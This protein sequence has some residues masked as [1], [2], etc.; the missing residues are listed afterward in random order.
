MASRQE[1][2]KGFWTN[3]ID[4]RV[5]G[6]TLTLDRESGAYLI[7]F[8]ALF[9][10]VTGASFWRLASFAIFYFRSHPDLDNIVILQQQT[11]F[12]NSASAI[13]SLRG[14]FRIAIRSRDWKKNFPVILW[15]GINLIGFLAAGILSSRVT[16][17]RSDVLLKP[18]HCGQWTARAQ[19]NPNDRD[20]FVMEQ[21]TQDA[22]RARLETTSEK[23]AAVC[24]NR[25][26]SPE[27]CITFGR[28]PPTWTKEVEASCPFEDDLCIDNVRKLMS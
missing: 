3:W 26:N 25:E 27:G 19:F 14:F 2:Y 15:A 8:L 17:T 21:A 10:H 12:R 11:V 28:R 24:Y 22:T 13:S 9:V 6:A 1:V 4:G 23:Y 16:S 7:A 18:T 20:N 5:Q